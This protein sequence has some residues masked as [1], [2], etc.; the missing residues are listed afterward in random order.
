MPVRARKAHNRGRLSLFR[1]FFVTASLSFRPAFARLHPA[2]WLACWLLVV[3]ALQVL[4]GGALALACAVLA[5]LC[6]VWARGRSVRLLRRLMVF[7]VMLVAFFAW[8]TPGE[9]LWIDWPRLSPTF[10]GLAQA[11]QHGGRLLATVLCVALL[12]EF[13]PPARLVGGVYALARPLAALG[14][15]RE[16]LA[17]RTLL[18]LQEVERAELREV[19]KLCLHSVEPAAHDEAAHSVALEQSAPRW[20]DFALPA[21]LL[22]VLVLGAGRLA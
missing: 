20:L 10:E 2:S 4:H 12:L 8:G 6:M 9:V 14:F 19:W 3:G 17:L 22:A 21:L 13:L 7:W 5:A 11:A 15:P 18:V 1:C 16:R